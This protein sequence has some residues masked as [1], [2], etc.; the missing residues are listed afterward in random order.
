MM[1]M[2][3]LWLLGLL[4]LPLPWLFLHRREY[5]PHS[6]VGMLGARRGGWLRRVPLAAFT[7]GLG[8]M[9][10]CLARPQVREESATQT[11][12]SRDIVIAVDISGSM[13]ATFNGEMPKVENSGNSELD[14]ALPPPP[15]KKPVDRYSQYED[16]NVGKRRIDAA[17]AAVLR[18][19][20]HRYERAHGDRIAVEV[21]DMVPRWSWPL[22]DDLKMIYRKGLFISQGLGGGTNFG[23][24]KPGPID[25]AGEH[26]VERGQ[27][28]TKVIILVTDGED[29]ISPD[30]WNRLTELMKAQG[31]RLYV[32]GVGENLARGN[33]D[34]FRL[35]KEVG[36]QTFS[37]TNAAEMAACF[38]SIDQ[39]E[40]S[41]VEVQ[42]QA[43][44]HDIFHFFA[45]AALSFIVLGVL[46]EFLFIS[47]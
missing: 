22:T 20:R 14:K 19:V 6:K 28:A 38:D 33:V 24:Q 4:L 10:I 13:G 27:A 36:G 15:P 44:Y 29:Y 25:A 21:F 46:G 1:L 8:L 26:F 7:V 41:P 47:R 39:M 2:H 43:H 17:Q 16:P 18:F 3:P 45:I 5:L 9:F 32:V 34:I 40:R 30:A 11:I 31:I 35:A 42:M 12:M 23:S 37:V